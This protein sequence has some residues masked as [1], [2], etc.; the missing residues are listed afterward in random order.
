M[1]SILPEVKLGDGMGGEKHVPD[2][3]GGCGPQCHWHVPEG[4][5]D[6]EDP[7]KDRDPAFVMYTPYKVTWPV[8]QVRKR[9]REWSVAHAVFGS[10]GNKAK[11][12]MGPLQVVDVPPVV[13][14][15]LAVGQVW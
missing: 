7:S 13:E 10:R 3:I 11:G 9:V 8:L 14:G 12:L 4:F 15:R 5:T 1:L 6:L 2:A